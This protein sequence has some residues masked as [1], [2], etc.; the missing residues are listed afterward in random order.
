MNRRHIVGIGIIIIGVV[1]YLLFENSIIRTFSG[2]ICAMGLGF[3]LKLLPL[4]K[5]DLSKNL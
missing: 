3:I 4:S 5:R 1:A 2:A